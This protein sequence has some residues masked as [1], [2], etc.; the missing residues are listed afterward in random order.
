MRFP[1]CL[2]LLILLAGE[3]LGEPVPK[4]SVSS[5][6]RVFSNGEHNA[7]TDLCRFRGQLYLTFRSCPDGHIVNPAASIIILRSGDDGVSWEQVDRF[8]VKDRDPRDPHFLTFR[9]R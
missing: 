2:A 1:L 8:S 6:R 7:F 3:L 5:V 4:V 9:D